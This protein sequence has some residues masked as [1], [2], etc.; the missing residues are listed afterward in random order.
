MHWF[1]PTSFIAGWAC[2]VHTIMR[3]KTEHTTN[4]RM[5]RV[6]KKRAKVWH[7]Y[8]NP[9]CVFW[10]A[11]ASA[12]LTILVHL[13]IWLWHNS[14]RWERLKQT[15]TYART[16]TACTFV[17]YIVV[18]QLTS[19]VTICPPSIMKVEVKTGWW[20]RESKPTAIYLSPIG[21]LGVKSNETLL[22]EMPDRCKKKPCMEKLFPIEKKSRTL[23][24]KYPDSTTRSRDM[25][26]WS[27]KVAGGLKGDITGKVNC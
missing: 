5:K 27:F 3:D 4:D 24:R 7:M 1:G 21:G 16:V 8:T 13:L 6:A 12:P 22:L 10:Y 15:Q 17:F 2:A 18:A 9:M 23:W 14:Q 26:H 25:H 11:S 20:C 19:K